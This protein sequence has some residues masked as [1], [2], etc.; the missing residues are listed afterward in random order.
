[1]PPLARRLTPSCFW[2][3]FSTCG[4]EWGG[5]GGGR[6]E[7]GKQNGGGRKIGTRSLTAA[8]RENSGGLPTAPPPLLAADP[9]DRGPYRPPRSGPAFA[10][11]AGSGPREWRE[12][13][14]E[15][16]AAASRR[17]RARALARPLPPH[18]STHTN[19]LMAAPSGARER[20]P[21][22]NRAPAGAR[23]RVGSARAG[24]PAQAARPPPAAS[25][26]R[27]SRACRLFFH[28]C[29]ARPPRTRSHRTTGAGG[30]ARAG[31][32]KGGESRP[33]RWGPIGGRPRVT[34]PGGR[35]HPPTPPADAA[36][37]THTHTRGRS[38]NLL[39]HG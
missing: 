28:S 11:A 1:M 29:H 8:P 14:G 5:C 34:A 18:A 2:N 12:G 23:A 20:T 16:A 10:V 22:R 4:V 15:G 35:L 21:T 27:T 26:R 37:H 25:R 19:P 24:A 13:R 31:V 32:W 7:E 38:T 30:D 17:G 33:D 3:A 39:S 6:G 36:P 9:P